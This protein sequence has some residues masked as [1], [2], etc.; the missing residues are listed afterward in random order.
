VKNIAQI[1]LLM[2]KMQE[3]IFHIVPGQRKHVCNVFVTY[4]GPFS[5]FSAPEGAEGRRSRELN[6]MGMI[7]SL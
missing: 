2:K 6:F 3:N 5:D 4:L 1:Y 7:S